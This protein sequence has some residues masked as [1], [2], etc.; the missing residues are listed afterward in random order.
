VWLAGE[1]DRLGIDYAQF[2]PVHRPAS[3]PLMIKAELM[4]AVGRN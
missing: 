2:V 1:L 4:D 3:P